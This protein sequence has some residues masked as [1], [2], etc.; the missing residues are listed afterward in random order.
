MTE[1]RSRVTNPLPLLQDRLILNHFFCR[2]FGFDDF[3][4]LRDLLRHTKRGVDEEG[5]SHFYHVLRTVEGLDVS[6]DILAEYDLRITEYVQQLNRLRSRP[7]QLLYFQYLAALFTEIYLARIFTDRDDF[8]AEIND[9]IES[10]NER[11]P[12][13]APRYEHFTDQDL[14][15]IAFWMATGSG[16]TLIA[17]INLW[18]YLHHSQGEVQHDN[19]LLI[20]PNEG[21]SRQ[22]LQEMA[23]S[24]IPAKHYGEAGGTLLSYSRTPVTV[25]EITKLTETK[26]GGGLRVEVDAFGPRNLLLVDEGHRGATGEQWRDLRDQLA[27]QGFTFEYSATF[28]QIVNGAA[29]SK[30]SQ[31]LELY[32]RAILFDYSYPH[33]YYDG[34]GKDYWILNLRDKTNAFNQWMLLGNLISFSEQRLVYDDGQEGF[35]PFNIEPPLWVFVGHSVTG[36]KSKDDRSSLT[37]VEHIVAFFSDFL[38]NPSRWIERIDRVLN[39]QTGLRNALGEDLF[40]NQ[41]PYLRGTGLTP[42]GLY[43]EIVKRGLRAAPGDRLRVVE[44]KAAPG[45]I[46]LRAGADNPYF[47]VVNIGDVRG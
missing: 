8:L 40:Q 17:H 13:K 47:G 27:E 10:E 39:H 41:F 11:L 26:R 20:T 16:K 30:R 18:Q 15:K 9:F 3:N 1:T 25:I 19:V 33:F 46:G 2:L 43:D 12:P 7:V 22:H 38:E 21:L 4:G 14:N 44:L 32:S 23:K 31:L 6:H 29:K 36:T 34:Y 35:R 37:D 28:G 42:K 5:H 45:E 24:G